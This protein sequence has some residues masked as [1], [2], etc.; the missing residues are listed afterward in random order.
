MDKMMTDGA[1]FRTPYLAEVN[2]TPE[3]CPG[4]VVPGFAGHNRRFFLADPLRTLVI[5]DNDPPG[6]LDAVCGRVDN[7]RI[8][9]RF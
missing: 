8:T 6:G 3:C 1:I 2:V 4:F 5:E 9:S 7:R